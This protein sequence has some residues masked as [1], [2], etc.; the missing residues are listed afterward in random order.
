VAPVRSF[1]SWILMVVGLVSPQGAAPSIAGVGLGDTAPEVVRVIGRPDRESITLGI[2]FWDY[3]ARAL[4]VIWRDGE[5]GLQGLVARG[6]EAGRVQGVRVGDPADA[7]RRTW[8]E[9][10]R[11]RQEGRFVD[12]VRPDWVISVEL[13]EGKV[14]ELTVM[15][16]GAAGR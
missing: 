13:A 1:V 4:T 6:P 11:V 7:A 12:F 10:T 15:R 2:R 5:P 14:R 9:P 3:K 8:G 16:P